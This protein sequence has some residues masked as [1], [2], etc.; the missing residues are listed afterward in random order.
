M[1]YTVCHTCNQWSLNKNLDMLVL[2]YVGI[3]NMEVALVR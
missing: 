1:T 2:D 3:L